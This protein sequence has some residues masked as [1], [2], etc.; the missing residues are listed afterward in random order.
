MS[1]DRP[2][3][4]ITKVATLPS[5]REYTEGEPVEL[6]VGTNGRVVLRAWNECRNNYTDVDLFDLLDWCRTGISTVTPH[7]SNSTPRSIG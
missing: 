5:V 4:P 3:L 7:G 2:T 1:D 6:W